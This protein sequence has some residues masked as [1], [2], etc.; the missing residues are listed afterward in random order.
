M[1]G[2]GPDPDEA[3]EGVVWDEVFGVEDLHRGRTRVV[4]AVKPPLDA[5]A[6]VGDAR[7]QAHRGFHHVQ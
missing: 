4:A 5:G 1:G 7:A 6:V 2:V 3:F